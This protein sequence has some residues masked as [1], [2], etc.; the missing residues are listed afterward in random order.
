MSSFQVDTEKLKQ[1]IDLGE[2]GNDEVSSRADQ[3]CPLRCIQPVPADLIP[4]D[5]D[6]EAS[7]LVRFPDFNRPIAECD[8]VMYH[9]WPDVCEYAVKH[10]TL[11]LFPDISDR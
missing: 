10:D 1:G 3:P 2:I 9:L 5:P 8:Q 7:P 4:R 6:R 11:G